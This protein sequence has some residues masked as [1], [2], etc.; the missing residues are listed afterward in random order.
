MQQFHSLCA[1]PVFHHGKN[2]QITFLLNG[3]DHFGLNKAV[4]ALIADVEIDNKAS[5]LNFRQSS[6]QGLYT[7]GVPAKS[8][9]KKQYE[10]Q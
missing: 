10:F 2:N 4:I 6:T 5:G 8:M 7:G 3:C 9:S 1:H